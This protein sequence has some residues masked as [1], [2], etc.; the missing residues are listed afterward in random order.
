MTEK[1]ELKGNNYAIAT[2]TIWQQTDDPRHLTFPDF[3][4]PQTWKN[5]QSKILFEDITPALLNLAYSL[6]KQGKQVQ[7]LLGSKFFGAEDQQLTHRL[8]TFLEVEGIEVHRNPSKAAKSALLAQEN[9]NI[10]DGDRLQGNIAN[11]NLP[12]R[13]FRGE[14]QWLW[15]NHRLQTSAS[16]IY[17]C[18]AV[19]GGYNLP[20]VA[21][22][23]TSYLAQS[24]TEKKAQP[25]PYHLVPYRLFEPYPF[26]HVGYQQ[27]DLPSDGITLEKA[28][29]FDYVDQLHFPFDLTVK[30]WLTAERKFLG[31]TVLGDR[32]GKLIY[33]CRDLIQTQQTF[34]SWQNLLEYSGIAAEICW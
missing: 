26:D 17:G 16:N 28:F 25:C 5:L 21:I 13:C 29:Y 8:Q 15:V 27:K 31:A 20:E 22:A 34:E 23:E 6:C 11:L 32:S 12:P 2:D 18:G 19:L 3:L 30:L 4:Q 1:R 9:I 10:I 14:Q 24:I 7:F 33:H